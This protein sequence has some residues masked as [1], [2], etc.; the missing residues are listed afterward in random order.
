MGVDSRD[1]PADDDDVGSLAGADLSMGSVPRHGKPS[2]ARE[3]QVIR[4]GSRIDADVGT[5]VVHIE[6]HRIPI[7][8]ALERDIVRKAADEDRDQ[9]RP[10]A[11]THVHRI[12][13]DHETDLERVV[14]RIA[15]NRGRTGERGVRIVTII[16]R[17]EHD[18]FGT[19]DNRQAFVEVVI[20][21]P[22][23]TVTL[24]V[25]VNPL[26]AM[27]LKP[28]AAVLL[29]LGSATLPPSST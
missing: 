26:A 16:A 24:P 27:K 17:P 1:V 11:G 10:I 22:V 25:T 2:R 9:I 23:L 15:I 12:R 21:A 4:S 28:A 13:R 18:G 6:G 19:Q 7:E 8:A 5:I 20:P 3:E 14:P 29:L